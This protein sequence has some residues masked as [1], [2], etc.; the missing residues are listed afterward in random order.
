MLGATAVAVAGIAYMLITNETPVTPAVRSP[1]PEPETHQA[2]AIPGVLPTVVGTESAGTFAQVSRPTASPAPD[3]VRLCGGEWVRVDEK[4]TID[5]AALW[6]LEPIVR[7]GLDILTNLANGQTEIERATA[8]WLQGVIEDA[9]RSATAE[10]ANTDPSTTPAG[11]PPAA[12]PAIQKA[13]SDYSEAL[14]LLAR[15]AAS[16]TDARV[17]ALALS[18]CAGQGNM[19]S[20][21]MLSAQQWARLDPG[22]ARPWLHLLGE[23]AEKKDVAARNE[24]LH[25]MA[26]SNRMEDSLSVVP[27]LIIDAGKADDSLVAA[28]TL[29]M[30]ALGKSAALPI[31]YQSVWGT[32]RDSKGD[33]NL[34][35]TCSSVASVM[36]R[37]SGLMRRGMEHFAKCSISGLDVGNRSDANGQPRLSQK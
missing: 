26:T 25:R 12:S 31:P 36:A 4:G 33:A 14:Q 7:A 10:A 1:S 9:A 13:L 19:G 8:L 23:A 29:V 15:H 27:A 37:S 22:N 2:N 35:Q 32:C 3:E 20:C 28:M 11:Q 5:E 24:A 17:Y 18:G 34:A 6:Q 30:F 21:G 16:T